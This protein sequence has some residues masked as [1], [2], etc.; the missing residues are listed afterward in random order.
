MP[1]QLWFYLTKIGGN[2]LFAI[3]FVTF[4]AEPGSV[5]G[6]VHWIAICA[7]GLIC[8]IGAALGI[9]L[10]FD[11]LRMRCPFCGKS[12]RAGGNKR[13]GLLMWC[14][15]CGLIHGSGPL[16]L[17]IVSDGILDDEVDQPLP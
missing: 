17:K 1:F 10:T 8:L 3:V 11:K 14:E 9:L 15:S 12:G 13:E 2:T 7:L 6:V 16:G 5:W 4:F